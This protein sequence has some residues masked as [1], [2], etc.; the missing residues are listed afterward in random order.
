MGDPTL[1]LKKQRQTDLTRIQS[2]EGELA[3]ICYICR[4]N[5][6]ISGTGDVLDLRGFFSG[7]DTVHASTG[8]GSF[9]G[10]NTTLTVTD[11]THSA[12]FQFTLQ[13][14]Y[15]SSTW[16]VSTDGHGGFNIVDPPAPF[17]TIAGGGRLELNAPSNET[18]SFTVGTVS[19]VLNQPESFTG[20]IV[21]F[22]G[23]AP[24]SAH[25]DTI[26]LI[27]L[28]FNSSHFAESYSASAGLL[29][30]TDGNHTASFTFVD[31]NATL[32]FSSDGNGGT[33]ITDPPPTVSAL[34]S[35]STSAAFRGR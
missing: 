35:V 30:V 10:T 15:S 8:A 34:P 2:S 13:G 31:F 1:I 19:L 21:G 24:D 25:S 7:S 11:V 26:D 12:T 14:D 32:N 23:T 27:G 18:V 28:D 6:R 9:N 5:D 22:A 20:Q 3:L 29:T 4:R 17:T 33:L 16:T